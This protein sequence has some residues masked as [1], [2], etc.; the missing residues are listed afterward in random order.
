MS[1]AVLS[2]IHF[3]FVEAYH[4]NKLVIVVFPLL[5]YLWGK[6]CFNSLIPKESYTDNPKQA[7]P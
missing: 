6:Y 5:C 3:D 1:R 4:Y 2:V 7:L